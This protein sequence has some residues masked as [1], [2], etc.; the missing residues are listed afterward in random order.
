MGSFFFHSASGKVFILYVPHREYIYDT[1]SFPYGNVDSVEL[2]RCFRLETE[3]SIITGPFLCVVYSPKRTSSAKLLESKCVLISGSKPQPALPRKTISSVKCTW[4]RRP[5]IRYLFVFRWMHVVRSALSALSR[6]G[7]VWI[8]ALSHSSRI[9][10]LK[11]PR[12][13]HTARRARKICCF[14]LE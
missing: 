13:S 14:S 6:Q 2:I 10:Q 9:R 3:Q 5:W 4:G 8:F 7:T 11:H 12:T 1:S